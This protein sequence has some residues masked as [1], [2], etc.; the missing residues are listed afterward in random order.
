MKTEVTTNPGQRLYVIPCG[1]GYS[2][3][4]FDV[5]ERLVQRLT[6]EGLPAPE[7][8]APVGTV[9]RYVQYRA[10]C[11]TGRERNARTG[12]RSS[13]ELTPELVGKEGKRVEVLHRWPDSGEVE[14]VRF[15]VGKSTG[16]MPCHLALARRGVSGCLLG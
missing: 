5:V 14:T 9:E 1:N 3:H 16:W 12:W 2:C 10:L 7:N 15:Q 4:G 11:E 13:A 8:P 6:A